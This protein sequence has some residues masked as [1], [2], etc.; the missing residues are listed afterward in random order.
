MKLRTILKLITSNHGSEDKESNRPLSPG[1]IGNILL[2]I[3][4]VKKGVLKM[5]RA[6]TLLI[7]DLSISDLLIVLVNYVPTLVML[8]NRERLVLQGVSRQSF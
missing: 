5:D 6:S 7:E 4:S 2:L 3:G 8:I 1:I